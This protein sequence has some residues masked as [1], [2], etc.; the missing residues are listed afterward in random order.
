MEIDHIAINVSDLEGARKFFEE[1]F[2]GVSNQKYHNPKTGLQTYFISFD[3]GSRLEL[4]SR[5]GIEATT[6]NPLRGGYI[7]LSFNVGSKDIVDSLTKKLSEAG[8]EVLDGPRTTGDG[9]YESSIKGFEGNI[10]EITE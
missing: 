2:E 4:M 7:H 1:F 8:Y 9:Y 3:D 10:I 6:F 5:P